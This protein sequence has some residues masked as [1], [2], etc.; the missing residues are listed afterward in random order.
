[1]GFHYAGFR[2]AEGQPIELTVVTWAE[3]LDCG[4]SSVTW[5]LAGCETGTGDGLFVDTRLA[6]SRWTAVGDAIV[7]VRQLSMGRPLVAGLALANGRWLLRSGENDT[8]AVALPY[9]FLPCMAA[10]YGWLLCGRR[11][12]SWPFQVMACLSGR[13]LP[14]GSA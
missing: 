9:S 1:M 5:C 2:Q 12:A 7:H 14:G 11:L 10:F 4:V 8:V 13:V 3:P 6:T